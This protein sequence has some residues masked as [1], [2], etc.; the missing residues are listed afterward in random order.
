MVSAMEVKLLTL[1]N[2]SAVKRPRQQD[3]PG[4]HRGSPSLSGRGSRQASVN[5]ADAQ[6]AAAP[7]ETTVADG[8]PVAKRRRSVVFGGELGPS[9]STYGKKQTNGDGETLI[10][11]NGKGKG[12]GKVNGKGKEGSDFAAFQAFANGPDSGDEDDEETAAG[13]YTLDSVAYPPGNDDL[14]NV[15]FGVKPP[16]LQ[17]EAIAAA[18]SREWESRRVNLEGYGQFVEQVPAA[19]ASSSVASSSRVCSVCPDR[20]TLLIGRSSPPS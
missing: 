4:G 19:G 10:N 9:G 7:T 17:P 13:E 1:L 8:E 14:F 11:G 12:K 20:G 6:S 15:H 18:D 16:Y 5:A 3:V 2:V